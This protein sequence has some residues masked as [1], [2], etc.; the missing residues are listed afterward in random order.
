MPTTSSGPSPLSR[1]VIQE[2]RTSGSLR[3]LKSLLSRPLRVECRGMHVHFLLPDRRR[4]RHV[5]EAE[6]LQALIGELNARL[7]GHEQ[8]RPVDRLQPLVAVHKALASRGWSGVEALPS[9]AL[10]DAQAQVRVLLRQAPSNTLEE[11]AECLSALRGA[12][13]AREDRI[14]RSREADRSPSVVVSETS[15]ED[16]EALKRNWSGPVSQDPPSPSPN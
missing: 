16:F 9:R 6:A 13:E 10:R 3:W 4:P 1:R 5:Q 7:K 11:L 2:R 14:A 8:T 15:H 12:A